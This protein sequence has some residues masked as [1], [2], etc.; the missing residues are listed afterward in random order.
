VALIRE[1]RQVSSDKHSAHK[2]VSCGWRAFDSGGV[3]FL[4]FDTYGSESR[5]ILGKVSQSFQ[6]DRQGATM[7]L[8]LI[9]DTFPGL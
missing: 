7:L 9:R 1:F 8:K 4:Q 5:Q 3:T 2:P 6:V